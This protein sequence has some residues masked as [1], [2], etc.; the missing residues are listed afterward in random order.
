MNI[1]ILYEKDGRPIMACTSLAELNL[2]LFHMGWRKEAGANT[3]Y[4]DREG[5]IY[6]TVLLEVDE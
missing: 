2:K 3:L 6:G 1:Y 5:K 4:L